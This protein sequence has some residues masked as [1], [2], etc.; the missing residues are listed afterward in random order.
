VSTVEVRVPD[1]GDSKDVTVVEVLVAPGAQVR[2]D[3]ALIT[4]ESEKASMDIPSTAAGKVISIGVKKGMKVSLG[5]VIA[6][7]EVAD[8][9]SPRAA[10]RRPTMLRRRRLHRR[11]HLPP[12]RR[13]GRSGACRENSRSAR[14]CIGRPRR[15]PRSRRP[16]RG[17]GR[18]HRGLPRRRSGTQGH[19]HRAL[20]GSRGVCLN[21]A[22]FPPRPCC[23]PPR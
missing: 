8:A 14:Y 15:R 23:M 5:M 17:T 13:V 16:R 6:T 10:N 4:L 20:A 18:L 12:R 22:A 1:I 7:V 9:A 19:A 11:P 3:D 2:I 21:V